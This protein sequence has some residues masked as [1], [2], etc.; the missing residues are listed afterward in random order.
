MRAEKDV[1]EQ[2]P[3]IRVTIIRQGTDDGGEVKEFLSGQISIGRVER[4]D[5]VLVNNRVSSVHARV[6]QAEGGGV[7]LIDNNST[8]GTFVNG[9]LVRGPVTIEPDDSVEIGTFTLH[10]E[11]LEV[12]EGMESADDMSEIAPAEFEEFGEEPGEFSEPPDLLAEVHEAPIEATPQDAFRPP[13]QLHRRPRPV[14]AQAPA[15]FQPRVRTLADEPIARPAPTPMSAPAPAPVSVIVPVPATGL[16][17]AF[18]RCAAAM[19]AEGEARS[20]ARALVHARPAVDACCADL[21]PR[22]RRQWSEWIAREVAGLG[23]LTDIL[24]DETVSEVLIQGATLIELRR[25]G[26][27]S[28]HPTRFSCAAALELALHRMIGAAPGEHQPVV[29][30][31]TE[32]EVSVHAVGHPLVHA[33]PVVLLARAQVGPRSLADLVTHGQISSEAASVLEDA[34]LR[35]ANLLVCGP[36]GLDCSGWVAAVAAGVPET[37]R[38]VAVHRGMIARALADR[39]I[40]VDGARDLAGALTSALRLRPDSLVVHELG[41]AEATSLC[42]AARRG[43]GSTIVSVAASSPEGAVARLAAMVSLGVAGDPASIRAYVSGCFDFVLSLRDGANG[44]VVA[45]TLA[46]IRHAH[47]GELVELFTHEA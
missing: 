35:G 23:A 31:V 6:V 44:R 38:V 29:D 33:G 8:N 37:C 20:E 42:A 30:G 47:A 39:A 9:A 3:M 1:R 26:V 14:E 19:A 25:D 41:G 32:G 17:G 15:P 12:E 28:R 43:G 4:N 40:V 45:G 16:A 24:A 2:S 5:L 7:T 36:P 22:Q 13:S 27:R 46:E 18:A 10:F 21:D 34:A 11:H